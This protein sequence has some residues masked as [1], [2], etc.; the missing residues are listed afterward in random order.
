MVEC[1]EL[2][3]LTKN[4]DMWPFCFEMQFSRF[5]QSLCQC[6][7]YYSII[8]YHEEKREVMGNAVLTGV[9]NFVFKCI[10][11]KWFAPHNRS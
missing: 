6:Q 11:H 5:L 10:N 7:D 3:G 8:T 4:K 1:I 9:L 2:F